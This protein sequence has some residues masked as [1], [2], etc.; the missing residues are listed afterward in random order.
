MA[1][2][3]LSVVV[4]IVCARRHPASVRGERA[5]SIVRC[6]R[7][8]DVVACKKCGRTLACVREA[9]PRTRRGLGVR[10]ETSERT[11]GMCVH[12]LPSSK[13]PG[14]GKRQSVACDRA[15]HEKD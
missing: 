13:M 10:R 8:C 6:I 4:T 14:R 3:S 11:G 15:W 12:D 2:Q 9:S 1:W 7:G 5:S